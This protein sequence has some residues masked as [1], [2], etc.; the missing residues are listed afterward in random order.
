MPLRHRRLE[1]DLLAGLVCLVSLGAVARPAVAAPGDT[2]PISLAN[3]AEVVVAESS[4]GPGG[5][6]HRCLSSDGRYVVFESESA[7]LVADDTNGA[8]D[9]FVRDRW[10]AQTRRVTVGANGAQANGA[11]DQP[12][13]SADG[14]FVAFGSR[15]SNLVSGDTNGV[16][17]LF[18]HELATGATERVNLTSGGTQATGWLTGASPTISAD[19]RFVAFY[20]YAA[21]VPEDVNEAHD[22][23][24]RDRQSGTTL[25]ISAAPDGAQP[26]GS[27]FLPAISADG[28]YVAFGSDASNLVPLDTSGVDVFVRDVTTGSIERV[29]VG[30]EGAVESGMVPSISAEG[31][32]VAFMSGGPL[33]ATDTNGRYDI[34]VRDRTAGVTERVSM[35]WNGRQANQHSFDPAISADGRFVA[36][37][38]DASNLVPGDTNRARDVFVRDRWTNSVR[39]ASLASS[40]AEGNGPSFATSISDDGRFVSFTSHATNLGTPVVRTVYVHETGGSQVKSFQLNPQSVLAFDDQTITTGRVL[41]M[42]LENT[43]TVPLWIAS[44][45]LRASSTDFRLSGS[46]RGWLQP[47]AA[48]PIGVTFQPATV[49]GK[50]AVLDVSAMN[51]VKSLSL[52]GSGVRA[53]FGLT[54]ATTSFGQ[55]EVGWIG[56]P[57]IVTIRNLGSSVLPLKRFYL[58]GANAG[59]FRRNVDCLSPLK[60]GGTCKIRVRFVPTSTGLKTAK[61]TVVAGGDGGSRTVEVS[62]VG[63][64]D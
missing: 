27:S 40:G 5:T 23:Y 36:F 59:Q 55:V 31:R 50:Q 26:N 41:T 6:T 37:I 56:G 24:L 62:G 29:S 19:G 10:L 8:S 1:S 45:A 16:Y 4:C 32:Y 3:G 64:A 33:E 34:Y 61:L 12:T 52:T 20:A 39:R 14:R 22:V 43:G 58:S 48:C 35:A 53:D 42:A 63:V 17:D 30:A 11:S 46:C 44:A 54:P 15:A 21:L 28:R 2:A 60:A 18:V 49:G 38:S 13:I 57:T 25:W 7:V 47:W 9:V 51:V